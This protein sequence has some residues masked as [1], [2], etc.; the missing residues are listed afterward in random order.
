LPSPRLFAAKRR[1]STAIRSSMSSRA[2]RSQTR[3]T[4]R[5]S[6]SS[7]PSG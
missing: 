1:G 4:A 7:V 6:S 5:P 2:A 3:P